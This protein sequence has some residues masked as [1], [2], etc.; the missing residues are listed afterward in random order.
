MP[1][2]GKGTVVYG[3]ASPGGTVP[4]NCYAVVTY[5]FSGTVADAMMPTSVWYGPGQVMSATLQVGNTGVN[6]NFHSGVV[7]INS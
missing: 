6:A 1:T 5:R 2:F 7:F 3:A 4:A